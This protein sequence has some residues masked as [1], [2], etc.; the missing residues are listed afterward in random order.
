MSPEDEV[1]QPQDTGTPPVV[2]NTA[3]A[4]STKTVLGLAVPDTVGGTVEV[5]KAID[6]YAEKA[7][8]ACWWGVGE[9]LQHLQELGVEDPVQMVSAATRYKDRALR[10]ARSVRLAFAY[11]HLSRLTGLG[12]TWTSVRELASDAVGPHREHLLSLF[13][14][15]RITDLE[16]REQAIALRKQAKMLGRGVSEGQDADGDE[17][18]LHRIA[19]RVTSQVTKLQK[20]VVEATEGFRDRLA[21]ELL[22][23]DGTLHPKAEARTVVMNTAVQA[24]I[25]EA[26]EL[27]ARTSYLLVVEAYPFQELE[28]RLVKLRAD[29]EAAAVADDNGEGQVA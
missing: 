11:D 21:D 25:M 27:L 8:A 18:E 15:G 22:A 3:A 29:F 23:D 6:L 19:S 20:D 16:I 13:E 5:I 14:N 1:S 24:L 12:L 26:V 28:D 17:G 2:Q 10:Y 7:T 4:G 9:L